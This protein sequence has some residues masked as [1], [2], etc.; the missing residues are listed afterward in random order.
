MPDATAI[1]TREGETFV[2]TDLARSPWSPLLLHGGPPAGLLARAV[3]LANPDPAM[4]VA[5]LTIDLFRP[6]P[7]AP[8]TVSTSVV[9]EGRRILVMEASLL[10]DGAEVSRASALLLRQSDIEMPEAYL[11][12]AALHPGPEGL[13]TTGLGALMNRTGPGLPD[14]S[15][16][17][18]SGGFHTTIEV[19]RVS[20]APGTGRGTAWI[21]IPV[22]FVLGEE[23]TPL[24]R[25]A[26]TSD[27]G[28]ALGHIRPSEEFGFINADITLYLHRLPEGEWLCLET[29]SSGQPHGL[30]LVESVMYDAQGPIGRVA[31]ALIVNRRALS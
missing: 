26:A 20:G 30:G 16:T 22:P 9:R 3:A 5:R 31:Q 7:K 6:V 2:P 17:P 8:L 18:A 13:P 11:P 4:H 28:N 21:R 19:R 10:A 23:T 12:P 15:A 25:A 1:F 14:Q 24:V 27:F 29:A